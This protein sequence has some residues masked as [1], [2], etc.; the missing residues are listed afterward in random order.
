MVCPACQGVGRLGGCRVQDVRCRC[1]TTHPTCR[2]CEGQGVLELEEE[3]DD[4]GPAGGD[5]A[6]EEPP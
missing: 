4:A 3:E 1:P 5:F 6:E 2:A